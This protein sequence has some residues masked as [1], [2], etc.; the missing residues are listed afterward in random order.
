MESLV[1]PSNMETC[2]Q[3]E[4]FVFQLIEHNFEPNFWGHLQQVIQQGAIVMKS[5]HWG[6]SEIQRNSLP[7]H[8]KI[9]EFSAFRDEC[10]QGFVHFGFG[11][12]WRM[13]ER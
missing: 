12:E 9:D 3:I 4:L 1:Y 2:S 8:R 10:F 7:L 6:T 11:K 5:F 13:L